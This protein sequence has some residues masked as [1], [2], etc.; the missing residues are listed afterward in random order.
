MTTFA[1]SIAFGVSLP[2]R[3]LSARTASSF[4]RGAVSRI[5]GSTTAS[6]FGTRWR[7]QRPARI[8]DAVDAAVLVTAIRIAQVMLQ[9]TDKHLRPVHEVER[10]IRRD[11]DAARAE[12]RVSLVLV[13]AKDSLDERINGLAFQPRT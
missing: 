10:A 5:A 6:G 9:M 8:R 2:L 12:V 3:K 7:Q 1:S 11:G 4:T 13:V